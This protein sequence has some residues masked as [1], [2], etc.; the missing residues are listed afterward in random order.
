MVSPCIYYE[1]HI[2]NICYQVFILKVDYSL[3]SLKLPF[4]PNSFSIAN[5]PIL[6]EL[7]HFMSCEKDFE[8]MMILHFVALI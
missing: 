6:N 2:Q 5:L 7:Y 4:Y 3:F 8:L 1:V